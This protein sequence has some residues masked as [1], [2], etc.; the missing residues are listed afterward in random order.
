MKDTKE[1]VTAARRGSGASM[2]AHAK[3][4]KAVCFL[5]SAEMETR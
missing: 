1:P 3:D 4:G 2:P 5:L